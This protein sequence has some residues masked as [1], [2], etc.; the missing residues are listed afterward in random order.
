MNIE[1]SALALASA[2]AAGFAVQQA[3]EILDALWFC[4]LSPQRKRQAVALTSVV[5]GFAF[6]MGGQI[7]IL[8]SLGLDT[9]IVGRWPDAIDYV[10]TGLFISAGTEGVN[11]LLKFLQYKKE[12]QKGEAVAAKE[13]AGLTPGAADQ[14]LVLP[15]PVIPTGL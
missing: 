4:R 7:R 15:S 14:P 2:F 6:A 8:N 1:K 9:F 5:L 12:E 13:S 11:S 10:I 3:L